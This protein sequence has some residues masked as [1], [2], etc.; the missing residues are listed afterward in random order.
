[1]AELSLFISAASY[2]LD[3]CNAAVSTEEEKLIAQSRIP[4]LCR[5]E[6]C[7]S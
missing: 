3:A 1:M 7:S 5:H 4:F 6:P 2:G